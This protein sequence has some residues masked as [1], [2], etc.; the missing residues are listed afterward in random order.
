[1]YQNYIE[2]MKCL[3]FVDTSSICSVWCAFF[4][5]SGLMGFCLCLIAYSLPM[6]GGPWA[7]HFGQIV[8]LPGLL[9]QSLRV[10]FGR[11]AR[12]GSH[13]HCPGDIA[14]PMG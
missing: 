4:S 7:S 1:M 6:P 14:A 5:N 3:R 2:H 9:Y 13:C 8:S 10:Y 11:S 12:P